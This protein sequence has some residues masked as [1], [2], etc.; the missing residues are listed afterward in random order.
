MEVETP[1]AEGIR[2]IDKNAQ[3]DAACKQV[4]AISP[5]TLK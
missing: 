2:T 1:V 3:L 4:L 5:M